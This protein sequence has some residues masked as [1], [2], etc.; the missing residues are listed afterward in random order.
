MLRTLRLTT[1][2]AF[3]LAVGLGAVGCEKPNSVSKGSPPQTGGKDA[4]TG[5][6]SK[7]KMGDK[8]GEKDKMGDKMGEKDKMGDKMGEK[9]KMGDKMGEKDKMGDKVKK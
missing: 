2:T 5:M 9:D 6:D 8:M 4:K 7:D 3:A 1:L